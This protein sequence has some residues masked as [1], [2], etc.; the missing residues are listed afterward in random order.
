MSKVVVLISGRGSNMRALITAGIPLTAVIS[1]RPDAAGLEIARAAGIT[2]EAVDH[3]HYPD[4]AG[5]DTAL[6][7]RIDHH[8]PDLIVLA[9][10]MRILGADFVNRY[11]G[12]LMNIHPSLLPAFTGLDTHRRALQAGCK[13]HG[14]T[15]HLVTPELDHGPIVS[16]A[17]VPVLDDDDAE[18][19]AAR[20]L[21]QEHRLLPAAVRWFLADRLQVEQLR[22]G[23]ADAPRPVGALRVPEV[24]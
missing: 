9:G 7:A 16:Q 23:L 20:V 22:V 17:A 18:S 3:R 5:F 1:N 19:L 10:F 4:R 6:A 12:R 24:A 11:A 2:A 15:V 14:C 21:V 8:A 13:I